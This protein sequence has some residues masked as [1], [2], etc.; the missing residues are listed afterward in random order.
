MTAYTIRSYVQTNLINN[1]KLQ[2]DEA[3]YSNTGIVTDISPY[4]RRELEV[5]LTKSIQALLEEFVGNQP[6]LR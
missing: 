6:W 5:V 3:Y 4:T 2:L 1:D